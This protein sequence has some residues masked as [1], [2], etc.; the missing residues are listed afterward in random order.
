MTKAVTP[1]AGEAPFPWTS[2]KMLVECGSCHIGMLVYLHA[3]GPAFGQ[4]GWLPPLHDRCREALGDDGARQLAQ[5]YIE[6]G[7][8]A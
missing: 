1:P 4:P 5:Y 7:C 3:D 2:D 6:K 8:V